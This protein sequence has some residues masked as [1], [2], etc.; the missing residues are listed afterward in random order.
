MRTLFAG[1]ATGSVVIPSLQ[2][3]LDRIEALERSVAT[4]EAH[5]KNSLD[6]GN[7]RKDNG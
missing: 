7:G 3:A 2:D 6:A 5:L 1:S 4:L